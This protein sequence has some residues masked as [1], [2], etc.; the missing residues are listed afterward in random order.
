[1][2]KKAKSYTAL[3]AGVSPLTTLQKRAIVLQAFVHKCMNQVLIANNIK[4]EK[5]FWF[6][7]TKCYKEGLITKKCHDKCIIINDAGNTVKHEDV[8]IA[9]DFLEAEFNA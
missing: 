2:A 8:Q 4:T 6:A 7:F 9:C 1:M 3:C 5:Y